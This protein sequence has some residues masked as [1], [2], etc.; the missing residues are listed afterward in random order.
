MGSRY[1]NYRNGKE[2]VGDQKKEAR[3]VSYSVYQ[4]SDIRPLTSYF[5]F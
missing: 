1:K 4:T 5:G 3:R 2:E